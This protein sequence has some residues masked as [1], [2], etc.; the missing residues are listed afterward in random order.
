MKK[1]ILTF[2]ILILLNLDSFGIEIEKIPY[3]TSYYTTI[4]EY[5]LNFRNASTVEKEGIAISYFNLQNDNEIYSVSIGKNFNNT[6]LS[7]G[8]SYLNIYGFF[9]DIQTQVS[10][11]G[12][13]LLRIQGKGNINKT[14]SIGL[15]LNLIYSMF[16]F[17]NST[18]LLGDISIKFITQ[19]PSMYQGDN[20]IFTS[21]IFN[22]GK[23]INE[24][25]ISIPR[26]STSIEYKLIK[27][28]QT[29]LSLFSD[30]TFAEETTKSNFKLGITVEYNKLIK[31]GL[32]YN[33]GSREGE[34]ELFNNFSFSINKRE[35]SLSYSLI[36]NRHLGTIFNISCYLGFW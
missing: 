2:F 5:V 13:M 26:F 34:T 27:F 23:T 1:V 35:M 32:V 12:E 20:F 3:E 15:G 9:S 25:I 22:L 21:S 14:L 24:N 17:I 19:I 4:N 11:I 29:I 33:L 6:L 30:L 28:S 7:L 16:N 31:S 18:Q 8:I 36:F 10:S